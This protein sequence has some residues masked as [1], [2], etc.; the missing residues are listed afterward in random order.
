MTTN[1]SLPARYFNVF[2]QPQTYINLLYL[3]LT[4]PL[5]IFYFTALVTGFSLG[6][7][8]FILW[9]GLGILV[10]MMLL[11][12]ALTA[13]ER[14]MAISM[15]K[16]SIP[17]LTD[18]IPASASLW[19]RFKAYLKSSATWKG[20]LYLLLKFPIAVI[21]FTVLVTMLAVTAVFLSAPVVVNFW[22]INFFGWVID[23]L[24]ESAAL[25]A[26]GLL[27]APIPLHVSNLLADLQ[28]KLAVIMLGIRPASA[29]QPAVPQVAE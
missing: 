27:G 14:G 21:N 6:I 1:S 11:S 26:L 24:P 15:L 25:L 29:V 2:L 19:E 16:V 9:I 22:P 5:G 4:F 12:I 10:L 23:T 20:L 17:P 18:P 8:L 28:G 13:F 7:G 3:F